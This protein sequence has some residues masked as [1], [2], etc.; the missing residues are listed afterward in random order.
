MQSKDKMNN[1]LKE[2]LFKVNKYL[3]LSCFY[4]KYCEDKFPY[5]GLVDACMDMNN[6]KNKSNH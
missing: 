2:L 4:E 1:V 3:L 6:S 5:G